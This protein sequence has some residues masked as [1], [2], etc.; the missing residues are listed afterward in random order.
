MNNS[1]IWHRCTYD[2]G[3]FIHDG[4]WVDGRWY[5]FLDKYDNREVARMKKDAI[6]HFFPP[7]KI[8]EAEDIIAFREVE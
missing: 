4:R 5:E 6:D 1:I 8:I 3:K 7:T 2:D